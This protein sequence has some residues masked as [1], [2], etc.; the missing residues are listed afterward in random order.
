MHL[1]VVNGSPREHGNTARMLDVM[2]DVFRRSGGW[3]IE[4]IHLNK[5]NFKGCQGCM[6]CKNKSDLCAI[7][8]DLSPVFEKIKACDV[9][10]LGSPLY[11]LD[12]T[13]Q[14]K[15]FFDRFFSFWD[16]HY[17]PRIPPGKTVVLLMPQGQDNIMLGKNAL[18]KYAHF[19]SSF[20]FSRV[21]ELVLPG[22]KSRSSAEKRQDYH[23][24]VSVLAEKLV[25]GYAEQ[26]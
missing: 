2:Q 15:L 3:L 11:F 7:R 1:L 5:L 14:F 17:A 4:E 22:L 13:G 8:D 12:V 9:I 24:R 19:L 10:L 26:K 21:E 23:E 6:S 20:G 25:W 18:A 16:R